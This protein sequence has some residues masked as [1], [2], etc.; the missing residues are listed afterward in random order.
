MLTKLSVIALLGFLTVMLLSGCAP[1]GA[2]NACAAFV[3]VYIHK[4]DQLTDGTARPILQNNLVG[5]EL[6]KWEPNA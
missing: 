1:V 6:C 5:M 2:A 3:P 4:D